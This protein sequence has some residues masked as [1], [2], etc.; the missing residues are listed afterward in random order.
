MFWK[1]SIY[2]IRING[3]LLFKRKNK[4]Y[5]PPKII[6]RYILTWGVRLLLRIIVPLPDKW[7][8]WN[9]KEIMAWDKHLYLFMRHNLL[10]FFI[11]FEKVRRNRFFKI[12]EYFI[13]FL[14][15]FFVNGPFIDIINSSFLNVYA[16]FH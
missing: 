10:N 14:S 2:R 4:P 13:S 15:Y 8:G 7:C 11:V 1:Q 12:K 16:F 6:D 3:C 5:L 9:L